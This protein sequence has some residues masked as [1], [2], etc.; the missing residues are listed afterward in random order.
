MIQEFT[1]KNIATYNES[2]VKFTNLRKIN[3]IYGSNGCGKTT[4]SNF[5]SF[6]QSEDYTDCEL[7]WENNMSLK[8]LVYNRQFREGNFGKG[9]ISGVFTLGHATKD[10]LEII[11]SKKKELSALMEEGKK[12]KNSLEKL[13]SDLNVNQETFRDKT[14]QQVYKKHEQDFK[15]AFRGY[16]SKRSFTDKLIDEYNNNSSVLIGLDQLKEKSKIVFNK[17]IQVLPLLPIIGNDQLAT[18]EYNEIWSK[19]IIGHTDINIGNLIQRLNI[20]DWVN[21]GRKYIQKD[22]HICPFCQRETITEEFRKNLELYFNETFTA[23][24]QAVQTWGKKYIAIS[25][26]LI[27]LLE[28]ISE[29]VR[30]NPVSKLNKDLFDATL[31]T[32]SG[33]IAV[34]KEHINNK[35]KEPSRSFNLV[36][37]MEV[38]EKIRELIATANQEISKHNQIVENIHYE[39]QKLIL[40]VW[41]FIIV[42]YQ[43]EI[44]SYLEEEKKLIAGINGLEK[45]VTK[46]REDY[47]VLNSEIKQLTQNV[48]S[49]QPSIDE[50]NRILQLY[51]FTN[52]QIVPALNYENQY[53]IQRDNGTLAETT[54]SEGEI[55]F[56]TFL[57]FMQLAKGSVDKE[58]IVEDRVLVID[59]PVCSLDSNVLFI[60][61]SLIKE[62]I[63]QIKDNVG[64]VRQLIVLTHNVYFHKEVSFMDGR[65]PKNKN[66]YYW[67]LRKADNVTSVK[68]YEMENPIVSSYE[69]LWKELKERNIN[70]GIT[71][72]NTMRRIIENYFKILGKFGDDE[73]IHKFTNPQEQEICR[74][75]I[76]WINDGSHCLPDDL[77]IEAPY[78]TIDKYFEVFQKIFEEM[79]H[80]AHYNMMMDEK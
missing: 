41:K 31:K 6:P 45:K 77:Y 1:I 42:E 35:H 10:E 36:S 22:S 29:R 71:I 14:W 51:G 64:N 65:T 62:M 57:Y 28:S 3:F 68:G 58:N 47:A 34:N 2:G 7:I 52:F 66:T 54:L 21:E 27:S 23:N 60:V 72:Q 49:V 63:K 17:N 16:L 30:Q 5:L 55:T 59:D 37:T 12:Q 40:Q 76:C 13:K 39:R 48:T 78:D 53:Q 18:I 25:T 69:L 70:S 75:L 56:I 24:I 44:K 43:N 79:G 67:I 8:T 61:S 4:V 19:K 9:T 20:N 80:I 11:E 73:L 46:L 38:Q 15:E 32:L 74:S 50:I 33:L 26:E